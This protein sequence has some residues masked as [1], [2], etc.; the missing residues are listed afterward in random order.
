MLFYGLSKKIAPF[1][2][3]IRFCRRNAGGHPACLPFSLFVFLYS[4]L[5]FI[6]SFFRSFR[7]ALLCFQEK[8][9]TFVAL[10]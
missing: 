2:L 6:R 8:I 3:Y 10:L 7:G 4:W 9:A 5:V 1:R